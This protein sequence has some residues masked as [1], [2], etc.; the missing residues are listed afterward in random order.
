M[1][2]GYWFVLIFSLFIAITQLIKTDMFV[3]KRTNIDG[4]KFIIK[5]VIVFLIFFIPGCLLVR[6]Y[7]KMKDN[8][9]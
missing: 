4:T 1:R 3:L 9:H 2:K 8:Q 6:W 5:V 7:Y